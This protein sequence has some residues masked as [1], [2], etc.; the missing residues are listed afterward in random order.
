MVLLAS[1]LCEEVRQASMDYTFS[2]LGNQ[3]VQGVLLDA[4][5]LMHIVDTVL[6]ELGQL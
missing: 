2:A 4:S 6:D 5:Y 1:D 3:T